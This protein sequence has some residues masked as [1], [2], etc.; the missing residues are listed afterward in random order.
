MARILPKVGW[1]APSGQYFTGSPQERR[2]QENLRGRRENPQELR[3]RQKEGKQLERLLTMRATGA[4]GGAPRTPGYIAPRHV[5]IQ[6][7]YAN[8]A[9]LQRWRRMKTGY[10][11]VGGYIAPG[12]YVPGPGSL[13]FM[14]NGGLATSPATTSMRQPQQPAPRKFITPVAPPPTQP[15][16][17]TTPTPLMTQPTPTAPPLQ[18]TQMPSISLTPAPPQQPV[19]QPTPTTTYQSTYYQA[20]GYGGYQQDTWGD[21]PFSYAYQRPRLQQSYTGI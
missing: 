15:T 8:L 19:Y 3:Q 2:A 6:Q 9:E 12:Q 13:S 17:Q 4:G 16:Y 1:I 20:N 11:G 5:T 18:P 21:K 10:G 14:G 7:K